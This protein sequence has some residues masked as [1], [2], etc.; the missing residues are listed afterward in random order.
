[1]NIE[2]A[3]YFNKVMLQVSIKHR[4]IYFFSENRKSLGM[5]RLL[6]SWF[7]VVVLFVLHVI[8]LFCSL[9]H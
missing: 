3:C 9:F 2:S 8:A 6:C 5:F 7:F 1:M 4:L